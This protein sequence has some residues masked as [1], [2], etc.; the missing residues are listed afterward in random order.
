M[1]EGI[2]N[3]NN[4]LLSVS[5]RKGP[6]HNE[7]KAQDEEA[8]SSSMCLLQLRECIANGGLIGVGQVRVCN[9][10]EHQDAHKQEN[11]RAA[12]EANVTC[13]T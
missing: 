3:E 4:A 1:T 13:N 9:G 12:K 5:Y 10:A 7:E 11:S 8:C 2:T 6:V